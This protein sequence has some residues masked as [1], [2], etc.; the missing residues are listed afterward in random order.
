MYHLKISRERKAKLKY[1]LLFVVAILVVVVLA[2]Y[3]Y[4]L[5]SMT[6]LSLSIHDILFAVVV[7]VNQWHKVAVIF[8][9]MH[10]SR[11]KIGHPLIPSIS[12]CICRDFFSLWSDVIPAPPSVSQSVSRMSAVCVRVCVCNDKEKNELTNK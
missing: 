10:S 2:L 7:I 12:I 6:C 3:A 9:A 4:L 1:V 5:D 8:C 11:C